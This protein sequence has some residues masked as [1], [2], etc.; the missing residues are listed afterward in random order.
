[1]SYDGAKAAIAGT[2]KEIGDLGYVDLYLLHSPHGGKEGRL[3]A[4]KAL[5]EAVAEG[6]VRSIGVSNFGVQH[7]TELE[8]WQK[9]TATKSGKESAGILSVNQVELHPWLGRRDI[10]EWCKARNVVLEAYCPIVRGKRFEDPLLVPIVKR[11]GK[12]AAQVLIRW[13]LQKGFVPLPKSVTESRIEENADVYDFE[14]TGEE[15]ERLE[16]DEVS[17]ASYFGGGVRGFCRA[18]M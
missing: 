4:W 1:M 10:V 8:T 6:K 17:A 11:T 18:L 2:M 14:L 15:M 16:T 7:L 3:G 12:T 13:S 9:E 5:V